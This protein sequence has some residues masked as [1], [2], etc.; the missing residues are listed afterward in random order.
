MLLALSIR[1]KY[2]FTKQ[3][4]LKYAS[5]LAIVIYFYIL[6][7]GSHFISYDNFSHWATVVKDM[8]AVNRMPNFED[9]IIRF[10]S[11][12]LGSSLFIYFICKMI[13]TSDACFL[14]GQLLMLISFLFCIV[15]FVKKENIYSA[16]I[17]LLYSIWALT[18]N[19]HIYE[20]RVDTL[21][22]LAGVAAFAFIYFY[23][24]EPP[25]AVFGSTGM[26]ILLI[27]IKNS[28]IFFYA[29]CAICLAVFV[30]D[31]CKKKPAHF[32]TASLFVPLASLY[33]WKQHVAFAFSAGMEA[34]HSMNLGHFKQ[35]A[36]KKSADDML[37]IGKNIL[38]QFTSLK[39]LGTT[40]GAGIVRNQGLIVL[41]LLAVFFL[42]MCVICLVFLRSRQAF[43]AVVRI[44][45]L[46]VSCLT[47][48]TLSVYAMYLFSMPP[49]EA[50]RLASFDRYMFSIYIFIY[51]ITVIFILSGIHTLH[52]IHT[53]ASYM[54]GIVT[55][56]LFVLPVNFCNQLPTLIQK[57][58]FACSKRNQLQQLLEQEGIQNGDSCFIYSNTSDTN[59]RYLFYLTRYELWSPKVLSVN[60]ADFGKKKKKIKK[61]DYFII[62][63]SDAQTDQ[64][65]RE[66]Q[67]SQYAKKSRIC[68]PT[69]YK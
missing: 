25:K 12:P 56:L 37:A 51:G 62:W 58:E 48:Y 61:Y 69:S 21:L 29:V 50:S 17:F 19:T 52:H 55:S 4:G 5:F 65:L 6:M 18:S 20:L 9:S 3:D 57:P 47:L 63:D 54:I 30:W 33:L 24:E 23:K 59:A 45:A 26:F 8:L 34:K 16:L 40:P 13:G 11:Y 68:I 41:V 67:L 10:Q 32:F 2:F 64:Y 35:E 42:A 1:Y 66:H 28:G 31:Y 49:S 7:Q 15:A 46:D 27:Q 43:H 60:S 22:P 44:I 38:K 53:Q 36:A 39:K 14:F